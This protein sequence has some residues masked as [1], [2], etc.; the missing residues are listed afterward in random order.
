MSRIDEALKRA[1]TVVTI[2]AP[3]PVRERFSVA[4][5]APARIEDY[6]EEA[7]APPEAP[8]APPPPARR[9]EVPVSAPPAPASEPTFARHTPVLTPAVEGKLV[10]DRAT[11]P[12]SVE[13]YRRLATSL[14]SLQREQGV[15]VI[16]VTSAVPREGKTLTSTNVALT[17]AGYRRRTLL[18]DADLRRPCIHEVFGIPNE[19]G[20]GDSLRVA[21][22]RL[23]TVSLSSYLTV[24]PAGHPDP[25]P[26]AG[27]ASERMRALLVEAREHF[28]WVILD[29]PPV[30]VISDAQLMTDLV[31]GVI[32]VV[33][34]GSTGYQLVEKA[35]TD[36]G[37]ERI[38]GTVLNRAEQAASK[39]GG[40]YSTYYTSHEHRK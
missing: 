19:T 7:P 22:P 35:I 29:S 13:Q 38:V 18:I 6:P 37:R 11:N 12:V 25:N 1:A 5:K 40:Y 33:D 23:E 21:E 14:L 4:V 39:S 10:T 30:G 32:F 26:L 15:K 3:V 36:I 28:D 16:M 24:L 27:L 8:I 2:D 9:T 31:D 20:L 17:L 34:A